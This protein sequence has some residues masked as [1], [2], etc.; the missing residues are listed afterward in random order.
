[1]FKKP[2]SSDAGSVRH[3]VFPPNKK[4]DSSDTQ[5]SIHAV[6]INRADYRL[7][8][9][10]LTPEPP[11]TPFPESGDTQQ[12][13]QGE[14]L[15]AFLKQQKLRREKET[16]PVPDSLT[17]FRRS[18]DPE[19]AKLQDALQDELISSAAVALASLPSR[20]RRIVIDLINAL[21]ETSRS[22]EITE[23]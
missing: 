18:D 23:T 4:T 22:S 11:E 20:E 7:L 13:L 1:M 6:K 17:D 2:S 15:Q 10:S 9:P 5:A 16:P 21:K 12:V 19:T 8:D 3:G 14:E